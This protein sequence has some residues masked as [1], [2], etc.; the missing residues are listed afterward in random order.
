MYMLYTQNIDYFR[1]NFQFSENKKQNRYIIMNLLSF[2]VTSIF[3]VIIVEKQSSIKT[4][5]FDT[6][7]DFQFSPYVP[8]HTH[9]YH[10]NLI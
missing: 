10:S 6:L 2:S 1:R 7:S 9:D 3:H 4:Q 8:I 5:Y